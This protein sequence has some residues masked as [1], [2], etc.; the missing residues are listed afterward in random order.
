LDTVVPF[1]SFTFPLYLNDLVLP[2]G[3]YRVRVQLTLGGKDIGHGDFGTCISPSV[4]SVKPP[5]AP[6]A[7]PGLGLGAL[8]AAVVALAVLVLLLLLL[9]FWLILLARRRKD[10]KEEEEIKERNGSR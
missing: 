3:C 4:A 9:V 6:R 2:T 8:E 10:K 5:A 7:R 1:T